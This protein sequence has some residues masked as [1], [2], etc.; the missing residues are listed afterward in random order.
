MHSDTATSSKHASQSSSISPY[1]SWQS[2]I[3]SE[4]LVAQSVR[5]A[6][7]QI[8]G[9]W[10]YWIESRPE[11]KGRNAIVRTPLNKHANRSETDQDITT[12]EVLPRPLNARSKA[13]E[14]GGG[15]YCV[16]DDIVYFVQADDQRIYRLPLNGKQLAV[17]EP[18]T[19]ASPGEEGSW[20]FADLR[21]DA[22]R[23]R[24]ICILE[25]HSASHREHHAEPTAK[26]VA[27]SLRTPQEAEGNTAFT[28][29]HEG[30]DFYASPNLSQDGQQLTWLTWN[31]PD[32]PWDNTD[33]W[34]A[35]FDDNGHLKAPTPVAGRAANGNSESVFQPKWAT[36]ETRSNELYF[37]SDRNNWWNIYRYDTATHTTESITHIEAEFATPQW[38][39]G[40]STWSFLNEDTLIATYTQHG[41]WHLALIHLNSGE[42]QSIKTPYTEINSIASDAHNN[43]AFLAGNAQTPTALIHLFNEARSP[44]TTFTT[45]AITSAELAFSTAFLSEPEAVTFG[46]QGQ[47]AHGFYYAPCNPE[48]SAPSKETPPLMV[49]CHGGPTGATSTAMNIKIQYWTSR[50]FA[51]LDVNYRGSTGYGRTYRDNLKG[52]WGIHDVEDVCN[53]AQY[54]VEKGLADSKR[55]AIKGSSAGGYTVLAALTF[56]DTFQVGCSLYGIGDLETLATDTHKFEARYLDSLVGPYPETKDTYIAR[57]PIH[58]VEQLSCPV[59]LFQGLDDKVVPPAQAESMVEALANKQLPVAY[60]PFEGEGHGFRQAHNIIRSLEAELYFYGQMFSFTPADTIEPVIIQNWPMVH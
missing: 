59:I 52:A 49:L 27:I 5:L 7:P 26:L 39:F 21:I 19:P 42:F 51:V 8:D 56:T 25:D 57:S 53:G 58:A 31:H 22:T 50:G 41:L 38:V 13:H 48:F 17:P 45:T 28:V 32:M 40:M 47:Q 12:E 11:E 20:R 1:G 29:L 6:E 30:H 35:Q 2:P 43:A 46:P 15:S 60:V 14:Y 36:S 54:L 24:L 3:T 33:C 16:Y 55:L 4:H 18:I 10:L 9:E 37:V 34:V 44:S 23:D